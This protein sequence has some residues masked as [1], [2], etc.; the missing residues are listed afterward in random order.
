MAQSP[1]NA[2]NGVS[3]LNINGVPFT[4]CIPEDSPLAREI[5]R[6]REIERSVVERRFAV[7]AA[8]ED[9]WYRLAIGLSALVWLLIPTA[10]WCA[11]VYGGVMQLFAGVVTVC[12]VRLVWNVV[13][14][15]RAGGDWLATVDDATHWCVNTLVVVALFPLIAYAWAVGKLLRAWDGEQLKKAVELLRQEEGRKGSAWCTV[16]RAI[17]RGVVTLNLVTMVCSVDMKVQKARPP[18]ER[19]EGA[20]SR[21]ELEVVQ[22]DLFARIMRLIEQRDNDS[23]DDSQVFLEAYHLVTFAHRVKME[24]LGG[25]TNIRN[26]QVVLSKI[27]H[28]IVR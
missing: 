28:N 7:N 21:A 25:P 2:P 23:N 17:E 19:F 6:L 13:S 27:D 18:G 11:A 8:R 3:D 14:L 10:V 26:A 22:R 24:M 1:T 20:A 9:R 16:R 5:E 12:A 15:V 4:L